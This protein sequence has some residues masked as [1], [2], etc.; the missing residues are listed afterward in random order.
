MG[1][2][3]IGCVCNLRIKKGPKLK[4][5]EVCFN[6][7]DPSSGPCMVKLLIVFIIFDVL[8]DFVEPV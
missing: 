3:L 4:R 8:D 6:K 7:H 5:F 2:R 1:S